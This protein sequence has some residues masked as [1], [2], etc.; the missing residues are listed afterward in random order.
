T[1]HTAAALREVENELK[2][3]VS[4]PVTSDEL[5]RERAALML[6]MPARYATASSILRRF[7]SLAFYGLPFDDDAKALER[8][9]ALELAAVRD[10]AKAYMQPGAATVVVAGDVATM[11]AELEALAKEGIFGATSVTYV[12]AD[13]KKVAKPK[14]DKKTAKPEGKGKPASAGKPEGKGKPA[15]A[16]KPEGKGKPASAGKPEGKGKGKGKG[17]GN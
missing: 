5:E 4:N 12:D 13:G 17:K 7:Q 8:I 3:M 10:S 2:G 6:S 11:G 14:Y 9:K 16:G 1:P 15:S